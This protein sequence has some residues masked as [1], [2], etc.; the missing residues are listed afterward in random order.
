MLSGQPSV[1]VGWWGAGDV[2]WWFQSRG[3][4]PSGGAGMAVLWWSSQLKSSPTPLL[5]GN[6]D[7]ILLSLSS[8]VLPHRWEIDVGWVPKVGTPIDRKGP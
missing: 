5:Q 8:S 6:R 3:G 4:S 7:V 1:G 2:P